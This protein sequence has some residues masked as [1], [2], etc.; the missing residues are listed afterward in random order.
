MAMT[1][2]V[3]AKE[4]GIPQM[5]HDGTSRCVSLLTQFDCVARRFEKPLHICNV[6]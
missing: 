2:I 4:L 1:E 6:A 5:L 3:N